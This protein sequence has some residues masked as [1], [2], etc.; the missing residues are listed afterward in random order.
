ML[1]NLQR[2]ES[3]VRKK[4]ME[5]LR[6]E[7]RKRAGR[8]TCCPRSCSI[9]RGRRRRGLGGRERWAGGVWAGDLSAGSW[10]GGREDGEER[11]G[12]ERGGRNRGGRSH[13]MYVAGLGVHSHTVY[14]GFAGFGWLVGW[15]ADWWLTGLGCGNGRRGTASLSVGRPAPLGCLGR[16]VLPRRRS[17][18]HVHSSSSPW[19]PENSSTSF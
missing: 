7:P 11:G 18:H 12:G 10:F 19:P 5:V 3:V 15:L 17:C 13:R 6:I 2:I 16:Q 1:D 8:R 4:S 9:F 14:N